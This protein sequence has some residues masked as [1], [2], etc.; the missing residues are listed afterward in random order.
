MRPLF[1][2]MAPLLSGIFLLG[3]LAGCGHVAANYPVPKMPKPDLPTEFTTPYGG[4][5][6]LVWNEP[7][8]VHGFLSKWRD[9][10]ERAKIFWDLAA[11]SGLPVHKEAAKM[12]EALSAEGIAEASIWAFI[13]K[14]VEFPCRTGD[15]EV[16]FDDGT[17][18]RDKGI[19]YVE[20]RDHHSPYRYSKESRIKLSRD[21]VSKGEPL[22]MI[23]FLPKKHLGQRITGMTYHGK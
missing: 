2:T 15:L 13:A 6:H 22:R 9:T 18:I 14:G 17:K 12:Y 19:L 7:E 23:I 16:E 5:T 21:I 1:R 10:S 4:K 20:I 3:L 8:R 11:T